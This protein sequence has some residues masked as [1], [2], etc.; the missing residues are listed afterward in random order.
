M[1]RSLNPVIIKLEVFNKIGVRQDIYITPSRLEAMNVLR[2]MPLGYKA[3]W[4]EM[5]RDG[6]W[7]CKAMYKQVNN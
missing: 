4:C 1:K 3:K 7:L 2:S 5:G 6:K